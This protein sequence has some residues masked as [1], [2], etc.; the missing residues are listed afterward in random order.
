MKKKLIGIFVC[1]LLITTVTPIIG[2][3]I[4]DKPIQND[5]YIIYDDVLDQ[6]QDIKDEQGG[7]GCV[8]GIPDINYFRAQSFVPTKPVLTR[9]QLYISKNITTIYPY[10]LSIR[11]DL[12]GE[13]IVSYSVNA[14][15]IP[16]LFD[17]EWIEF[18]FENIPVKIGQTYYLVSRTMKAKDNCFAWGGSLY[19]PYPNG[20]SY[21][22]DDESQ[23]WEEL[24]YGDMC[25]RTYGIDT[26][27]PNKP[28]ITG[29]TSGKI[30]EEHNYSFVSTDPDGDE[31]SY[32]IEWG[33]STYTGWTRT[34]SSGESLNASHTWNQKDSYTIRAKAKDTFGAESDWATLEIS[35]PKAKTFDLQ[36]LFHQFLEN[37]PHLF[38]LLRQLLKV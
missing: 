9:V 29:P 14:E 38:P 27:P 35:M 19:N 18:D 11:K 3:Q 20:I 22:S 13:D 33:D 2:I 16:T 32:Y 23:S 30:N 6:Y 10:T 36:M 24:D 34:L 7:I 28:S 15:D 5:N 17:F 26:S 8:P 1:M 25:F 4:N 31:I 37:H 21:V 12:K